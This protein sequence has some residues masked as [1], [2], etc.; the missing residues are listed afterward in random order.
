MAKFIFITFKNLTA[1]NKTSYFDQNQRNILYKI[2][3]YTYE[4]VKD[5]ILP[6]A[7]NKKNH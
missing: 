2:F 5:I 1:N 4:D 6:M 3:G 7:Q